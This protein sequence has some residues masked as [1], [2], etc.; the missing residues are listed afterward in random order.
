[1]T[2]LSVRPTSFDSPIAQALLAAAQVD[3]VERYGSGDETP[4]EAAEFEP[5][6]GCFIVAWLDGTPV[7]CGGWRTVA[8]KPQT[9][10]IKRMYTTP[11]SRRR[12]VA[13]AVLAAIEET[14][15]TAGKRKLVLETALRQPEAMALYERHGYHRIANFGYY[16]ESPISVS[17]GRTIG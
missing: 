12:G 3:L 15:R 14:A 13:T 16:R 5:P 11:G 2:G 9:V 6:E 17:Y 8:D 7:G 4:M 1:V 10:E